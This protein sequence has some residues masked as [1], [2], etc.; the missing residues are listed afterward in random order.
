MVS[1]VDDAE[2]PKLVASLRQLLDRVDQLGSERL[3]LEE[4]LRVVKDKDDIL[5]KVMSAPESFDALF[6]V[7]I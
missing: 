3:Q 2:A 6:Q 1:V 7:R 5:P 4:E